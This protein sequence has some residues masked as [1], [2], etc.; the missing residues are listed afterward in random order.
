MITLPMMPMKQDTLTC[1]ITTLPYCLGHMVYKD[2]C[3]IQL[4]LKTRSALVNVIDRPEELYPV[5]RVQ[6]VCH[7]VPPSV[8]AV[9]D[10]LFLLK[11]D[12]HSPS[13]LVPFRMNCTFSPGHREL[14]STFPST[15]NS[16]CSSETFS[17]RDLT[18]FCNY[19]LQGS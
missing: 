18:C 4:F 7:G 3:F 15:D 1:C 2:T 11:V 17:T 8:D 19:C 12:I 10:H 16:V 13:F 5:L 14:T 9:P 6:W